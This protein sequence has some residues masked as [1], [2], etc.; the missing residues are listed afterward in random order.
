MQGGLPHAPPAPDPPAR[1][2]ARQRHPRGEAPGVPGGNHRLHDA[3]HHAAARK[4]A[5]HHVWGAGALP[6]LVA[7]FGAGAGSKLCL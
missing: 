5:G 6:V 7:V 1:Q 3:V 4:H 2:P